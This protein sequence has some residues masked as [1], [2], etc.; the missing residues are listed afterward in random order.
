MK[1]S[2]QE[3]SIFKGSDKRLTQLVTKMFLL[4]HIIQSLCCKCTVIFLLQV[5]SIDCLEDSKS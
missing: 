5:V 3:F 4:L 2:T 1:K